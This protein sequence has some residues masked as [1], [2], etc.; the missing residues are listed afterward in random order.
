ME[1]KSRSGSLLVI[2]NTIGLI[3]TLVVNA[4]A[5]ALPLNG[6]N[7]GEIS[8]SIPN[9]FVPSGTT[10]AIWGVIYVLL[11]VLV[12]YQ[13]GQRNKT[14]FPDPI[15]ALG[16]WFF[17][18]CLANGAWIFAWHWQ[19]QILSVLI[20]LVL[21]ISLMVMHIRSREPEAPLGYRIA[22]MLPISVYF[23]WITVATIANVTS[24]LVVLDWNRFGL[25]QVFWTVAVIVVAIVIN[26]LIV[27][28]KGDPWFALVGIWALYGIYTKRTMAEFDPV[29]AVEYATLVGMGLIGMAILIHLFV[30]GRKVARGEA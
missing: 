4:L 27:I 2:L 5:N 24:V 1:G 25:S 26:L 23:G 14:A 20:M 22:I 6:R 30:K 16:I 28:I 8:D 13:I 29:P 10:F 7:T 21:L 18:S 11:I 15:E 12:V 3:G 19:L 17:I 9:L